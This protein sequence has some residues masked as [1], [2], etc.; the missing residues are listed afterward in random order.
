MTPVVSAIVATYN[1]PDLLRKTLISLR[2]QRLDPDLYEVI[3]IDDGS[4]DHTRDMLEAFCAP[5]GHFRWYTQPN[6]GPAAARNAGIRQARGTYIAITDH[7][8]IA[9]PDWL[10]AIHTIFENNPDVLGIEGETVSLPEQITPFTHQVVNRTGGMYA[11]CNIAYRK[12]VLDQ[13]H[14]FD[15]DFPYGHEDTE[16]SLRVRSLGRIR[17]SPEAR[18]LHPPIPISFKKLVKQSAHWRNEFILYKKQPVWYRQHHRGPLHTV[19]VDLCIKLFFHLMKANAKFL[20]RSPLVYLKFCA[21]IAL[22]RLYFLTLLP[23]YLA[24]YS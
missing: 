8:C 9:D 18:I 13:L 16:L 23:R 24:R 15:E 7:D 19:L 1:A 14:G 5:L 6:Q 4:T 21:A 3:V 12:S 10:L 17:F 2:D 11:T 22:Q 20:F